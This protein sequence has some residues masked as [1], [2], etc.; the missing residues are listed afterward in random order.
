MRMNRK[1]TN[2]LTA[3]GILGAGIVIIYL[4]FRYIKN[5][6]SEGFGSSIQVTIWNAKQTATFLAEDEDGYVH[7]M[8]S[9]DLNARAANSY[10]SYIDRIKQAAQDP[11]PWELDTIRNAV[12][13]VDKY[14]SQ[15]A[16][17]MEMPS[18]RDI[19]WIIAITQ[20]RAYED[21]F[22][23]TR[24]GV[25]FLNDS[26]IR[27]PALASTLLHEKVHVYQRMHPAEAEMWVLRRGFK[28]W[29]KRKSERLSRA[30]PD[31]DEWIYIDPRTSGPMVA[32][33]NSE[34][35]TGITDVKL[36]NAAFEHPYEL[37]A[38][39]AAEKFVSIQEKTL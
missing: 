25:I 31:L 20:G 3:L 24:Q 16:A 38:Y 28:K 22:P 14:L 1:T 34:T 6:Y 32:L 8:S 17:S 12:H 19:P 27:S 18:I 4:T 10:A 5:N 11:T 36:T 33:Y 7:S 9:Y 29:Q 2:L 39:E 30:N 15:N 21:G 13:L 23:H 35:P 26:I 37:M